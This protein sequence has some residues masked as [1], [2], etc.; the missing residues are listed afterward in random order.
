MS[1]KL[2]RIMWIDR[3]IRSNR[4]PNA[5][6]VQERFE[7]KSKRTAYDDRKFMIN[8]L[9]A[10]IEY[11]YDHNGWFYLDPTYVVP[12]FMLTK[13]EVIAF[14]LGERLFRRYLGTSFE[15]PLRMALN[16]MKEYLP[17]HVSV[18]LQAEASGF[19][20]TGGATIESDPE[21]M[22]ELHKAGTSKHQVEILYYSASSNE[23]SRRVVDP[24]HLH[25]IRGDWYLIAF[26]HR[27][28]EVRDFLIGRI[29]ELS[30][31]PST[32]RIHSGFSLAEYLERGFLAERGAQTAEVVIKFDE[33]QARW[34]RERMWHP[35]Q[36]IEEL[37]SGGL[38]LRLKVGGLQ[39]VKRWVMGYG[40]HAEVLEPR[41]LRLQFKEE[42]EKMRKIYNEG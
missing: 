27:R 37:P 23:L 30:V 6:K 19:A 25:N 2:E 34:I 18:D 12:P 3:E 14:F 20:F 13:D 35:S 28:K 16:R 36:E 21:V 8:R 26:C 17:E 42:A 4:Y 32:F 22:V 41:S 39:E 38:I 5:N 11:D 40:P 15:Q 29:K 7:L 24:Y 9:G 1:T 31:L 33:Y 10:P